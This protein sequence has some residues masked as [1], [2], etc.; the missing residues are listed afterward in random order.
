METSNSE[1][2]SATPLTALLIGLLAISTLGN[3]AWMVISPAGWYA[4][5]PGVT[6]TG[7]FN[8][9][10]IL[11]IGFIYL[12]TGAMLAAALRWRRHAAPLVAGSAVWVALHAG[13]HVVE[14]GHGLA[15]HAAADAAGV[16]APAFIHVSIALRL[17]T[18]EKGQSHAET[19][20]PEQDRRVRAQDGL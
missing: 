2:W 4:A 8:P 18:T 6:H 12:A 17:L 10:F 7:P 14:I 13:L 5:V 1:T 9:H 16:V 3:G 11:D 15:G 19:V 20:S